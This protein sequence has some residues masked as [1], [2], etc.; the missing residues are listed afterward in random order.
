[1]TKVALGTVIEFLNKRRKPLS[2]KERENK[3]LQQS[4]IP[5]YYWKHLIEDM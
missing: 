3:K 1:M 4:N 5:K 2:S